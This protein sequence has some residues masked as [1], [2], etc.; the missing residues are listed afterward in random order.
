M[1]PYVSQVHLLKRQPD[2][3]L[4]R[5]AALLVCLFLDQSF[6]YGE[7][8]ILHVKR[9]DLEAGTIVASGEKRDSTHHLRADTLIEGRR[10]SLQK[11]A[12]THLC[13]SIFLNHLRARETKIR[14]G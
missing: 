11:E 6:R 5:R 3:P 10:G 13:S 14:Q 12:T 2:T 8:Y 4:G 7:V 9:I 1:T